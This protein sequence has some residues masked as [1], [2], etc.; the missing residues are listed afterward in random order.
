MIASDHS[1]P[2]RNHLES[3]LPNVVSTIREEAMEM[4]ADVSISYEKWR[5][6]AVTAYNAM[7]QK[8]AEKL[9]ELRQ[10]LYKKIGQHAQDVQG[11]LLGND[12][13]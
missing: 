11:S 3:T 2:K 12:S 13:M 4:Y 7:Y 5:R 8:A 6:E 10:V 1:H 9:T